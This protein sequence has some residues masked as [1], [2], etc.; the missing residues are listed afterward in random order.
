MPQFERPGYASSKTK[1]MVVSYFVLKSA[2][3]QVLDFAKQYAYDEKL[4]LRASLTEDLSFWELDGYVFLDEFQKKFSVQLPDTAY[5]YVCPPELKG[6]FGHRLIYNL[7]LVLAIPFLFVYP[8]LPER[9]VDKA[10]KKQSF[11]R[12]TLGD[13]AASLAVGYFVK[14]E[15]V[16]I[17]L[18]K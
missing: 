17:E 5:G 14:R 10:E 18:P 16:N 15:L 1:S 6:S 2:T 7:T 13:L 3:T 11:N 9:R 8:F 12:L 4:D